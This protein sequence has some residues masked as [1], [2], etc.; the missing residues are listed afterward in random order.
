[1][2][3]Y[4]ATASALRAGSDVAA[5]QISVSRDGTCAQHGVTTGPERLPRALNTVQTVMNRLADRGL[6][7]RRRVGQAIQYRPAVSEV[8]HL[9]SALMNTLAGGSS[10]ARRN[11]LAKLLGELDDD[12]LESVRRLVRAQAPRRSAG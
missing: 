5:P 4:Q 12:E 6:L 1:M 10:Q 3:T 2:G 11:A 8:D 7:T 9:S